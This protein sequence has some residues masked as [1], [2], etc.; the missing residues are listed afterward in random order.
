MKDLSYFFDDDKEESI[1]RE[2][3]E[4]EGRT[5]EKPKERIP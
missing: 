4:P 2:Y 5:D 1:G 3:G